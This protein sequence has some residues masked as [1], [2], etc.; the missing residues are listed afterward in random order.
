V[1]S[2]EA[3]F[4]YEAQEKRDFSHS[5]EMTGREKSGEIS[6]C[7]GRPLRGS[8][9]G[10]KSLPAPFEMTVWG[11]GARRFEGRPDVVAGRTRN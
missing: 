1:T 2:G 8:E 3:G 10:R 5:F 6:L 11:D 4:K 7:A 9:A